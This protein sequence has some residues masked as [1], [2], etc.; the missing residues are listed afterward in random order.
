MRDIDGKRLFNKRVL[1]PEASLNN[2]KKYHRY[3]EKANLLK[4]SVDFQYINT[5]MDQKWSI[6]DGK[7]LFKFPPWLLKRVYSAIDVYLYKGKRYKGRIVYLYIS[8]EYT[9]DGHPIIIDVQLV[10]VQEPPDGATVMSFRAMKDVFIH[11]K[12]QD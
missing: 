6:A 7:G 11:N 1:T 9:T 10:P 8:E 2:F 5:K 4:C 3:T 12:F